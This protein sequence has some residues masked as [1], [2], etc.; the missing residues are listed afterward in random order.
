MIRSKW[1]FILILGVILFVQ[2]FELTSYAQTSEIQERREFLY[3][4][5]FNNVSAVIKEKLRKHEYSTEL[6]RREM[7]NNVITYETINASRELALTILEQS[8]INKNQINSNIRYNLA[9]FA[10]KMLALKP[11]APA[12]GYPSEI[13]SM[14]AGEER[15]A[16]LVSWLHGHRVRQMNSHKNR[17]L[18]DIASLLYNGDINNHLESIKKMDKLLTTIIE[19]MYMDDLI[20][21][22]KYFGRA[23]TALLVREDKLANSNEK[24]GFTKIISQELNARYNLHLENYIG[25]TMIFETQSGIKKFKVEDGTMMLTRNLSEG[26]LQISWAAIPKNL[27][28]RWRARF[29]GIIGSPLAS[30]FFVNPEDTENGISLWMRIRDRIAQG[31]ILREGYSHIVYFEIKEDSITGIKMPRVIDN[32]PS[33]VFDT[34]LEYVRTGGTRFTYPE[35]VIDISHHSAIYITNPDPIKVQEWSKSSANEKNY[36]SEFFPS[37]ELELDGTTPVKNNHIT[38]WKTS[39]TKEEFKNLH[40]ESDPQKLSKNIWKQFTY[41]LEQSVYEGWVFHWPD[42]YDFY[43][44]GATYC[45][46]LSDMVMQKWVGISIEQNKSV[47]HWILRFNANIGKIGQSLQKTPGLRSVGNQLMKLPGVQKSMKLTNI[48]IISPTSVAL[49]RFMKGESLIFGSKSPEQRVQSSYASEDYRE[50]DPRVTAEIELDKDFTSFD[51]KIKSFSL[52]YGAAMRDVEY[53]IVMRASRGVK[54]FDF[55]VDRIAEIGS[56]KEAKRIGLIPVGL[57]CRKLFN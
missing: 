48:K 9:L 23:L 52:D 11:L 13:I 26:S 5:G 19:R 18:S 38:N 54:T 12:T 10:A 7:E 37:I 49:Q 29:K 45:S 16:A 27:Y 1:K 35:Q 40:S 22:G 6:N 50:T 51:N 55:S 43:L 17:L 47:W 39:I 44:V 46:Q 20:G 24:E 28:D 41:G 42:P 53:G 4:L 2:S 36:K 3:N 32:Y 34:T 15:D 57:T 25:E 56:K 31:G 8:S 14:S 21:N 30:F 33:R